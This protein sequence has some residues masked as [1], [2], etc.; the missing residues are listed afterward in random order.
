MLTLY[1]NIKR[2]R[3]ENGWSQDELAKRAGYKNRS[4]I[5]RIET[6]TIDLPQSKILVFAN[7]FGV[8]PA[9]LMGSDGCEDAQSLHDD[10]RSILRKYEQLNVAGKHKLH[11]RADELI[12]LGYTDELL[13]AHDEGAT[14]DQKA[15]ALKIMEDDDEWK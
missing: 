5:A 3:E 7:I 11:E 2:L 10:E 4:A 8:S 9:D 14:E 6:G 15:A 1:K 13:A 12:H